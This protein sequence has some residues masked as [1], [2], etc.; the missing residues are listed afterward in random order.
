MSRVH[1]LG[2]EFTA[3]RVAPFG[4]VWRDGRTVQCV[5]PSSS[6]GPFNCAYGLDCDPARLDRILARF[7]THGVAPR[8]EVVASAMRPGV[9]RLLAERG[10]RPASERVLLQRALAE[11]VPVELSV[12]RVDARSF[13]RFH[14]VDRA[15]GGNPQDRPARAFRHWLEL[16]GWHLF[17]AR[18]G[19][20]DVGAATLFVRGSLAWLASAAT[21]P[22]FRGQ[23]V[24]RALIAARIN[25]A[26]RLGARS[27][28]ARTEPDTTSLRNLWRAGLRHVE[29]ALIHEA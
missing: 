21:L 9:A 22:R 28:A 29:T 18:A 6:F 3:M 20:D 1:V 24:Q 17:L 15:A 4:R 27:I 7:A 25:A 11:P 2:V 16:D 26:L 13:D 12:E 5:L 8:V 19:G 23:G 14:D 10:L